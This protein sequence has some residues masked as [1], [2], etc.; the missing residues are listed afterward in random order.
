MKLIDQ[1]KRMNS[2]PLYA[3]YQTSI[4]NMRPITLLAM[5]QKIVW[6]KSASTKAL[7]ILMLL[8]AFAVPAQHWGVDKKMRNQVNVYASQAPNWSGSFDA[9]CQGAKV[10]R[11]VKEESSSHITAACLQSES[12]R[13]HLRVVLRYTNMNDQTAYMISGTSLPTTLRDSDPLLLPRDTGTLRLLHT[14]NAFQP[15]PAREGMKHL[16]KLGYVDVTHNTM[17]HVLLDRYRDDFQPSL[18]IHF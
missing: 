4:P 2:Q 9:A 10:L 15:T 13:T 1:S 7:P 8:I 12:A 11:L 17:P 14:A 3:V 16:Q 6:L 5:N 18:S